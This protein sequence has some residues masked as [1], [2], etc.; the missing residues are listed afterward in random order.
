MLYIVGWGKRGTEIGINEFDKMYSHFL[1]WAS[2]RDPE[3][4]NTLSESVYSSLYRFEQQLR[5]SGSY[6]P[7]L[8]TRLDEGYVVDT[9]RKPCIDKT[10]RLWYLFHCVSKHGALLHI[11]S[12]TLC[13]IICPY[14]V[15]FRVI[16][17]HL[18]LFRRA[19]HNF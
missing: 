1:T 10:M 5:F 4:N 18:I 8:Q 12:F 16:S 3:I 7:L 9:N 19:S 14:F 15:L 11:I 13:H 2:D 6:I 17:Q